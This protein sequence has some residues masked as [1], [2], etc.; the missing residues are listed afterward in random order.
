MTTV[1]ENVVDKVVLSLVDFHLDN[2]ANVI[3]W[4]FV[5]KGMTDEEHPDM[6]VYIDYEWEGEETG[7]VYIMD[8]DGATEL[9]NEVKVGIITEFLQ[10]VS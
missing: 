6:G 3:G 1:Y 10:T 9:E 4:E 7:Y 5:G 2:K 8:E